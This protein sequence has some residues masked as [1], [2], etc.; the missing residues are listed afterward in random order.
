MYMLDSPDQSAQNIRHTVTEESSLEHGCFCLG[1]ET[2][3]CRSD[4]ISH[5]CNQHMQLCGEN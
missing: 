3:A 5:P 2:A 1:S 4:S